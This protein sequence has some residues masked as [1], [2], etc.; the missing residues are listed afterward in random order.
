MRRRVKGE[1]PAVPRPT[2][3]AALAEIECGADPAAI[4]RLRC[5]REPTT[6]WRDR[7]AQGEHH[8][9]QH[10]RAKRM[11]LWALRRDRANEVRRTCVG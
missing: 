2:L 3:I 6:W 4:A 7:S 1:R 5:G 8:R 10:R 11:L 9:G